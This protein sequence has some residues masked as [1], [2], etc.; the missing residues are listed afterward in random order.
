MWHGLT[1][2]CGCFFDGR[3]LWRAVWRGGPTV[4]DAGC[5][6]PRH[7][8]PQHTFCAPRSIL[9]RGLV[10]LLP[11]VGCGVSV[12]D[13]SANWGDRQCDEYTIRSGQCG[14]CKEPLWCDDPGNSF[15]FGGG[16]KGPDEWMGLFHKTDGGKAVG[17]RQCKWKRSQKQTFID[18]MRTRYTARMQQGGFDFCNLWNEVRMLF[19][20]PRPWRG[21]A[22]HAVAR[23]GTGQFLCGPR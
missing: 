22:A 11:A 7:R 6:Q 18:T 10:L 19:I 3:I 2:T 9:P 8:S 20:M 4:Q 16:I 14:L 1:L 17:S 23:T 5:R 12:F 13:V 15:G 21:W